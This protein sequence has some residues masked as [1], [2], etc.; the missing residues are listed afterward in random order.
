MPAESTD[1]L[2]AQTSESRL[3]S[4]RERGER[5]EKR[6]R[7]EMGVISVCTEKLGKCRGGTKILV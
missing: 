2:A 1:L 7:E 6:E 4:R 5:R 3:A